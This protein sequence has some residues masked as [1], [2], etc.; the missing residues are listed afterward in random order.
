MQHANNKHHRGPLGAGREEE[1]GERGGGGGGG[2][3]RCMT[4]PNPFTSPEIF[5]VV[6]VITW[7]E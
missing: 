2:G 5:E 1:L 4:K 3:G 7:L 6:V